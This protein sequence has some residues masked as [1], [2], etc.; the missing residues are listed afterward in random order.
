[1]P[2]KIDMSREEAAEREIGST[3]VS[4]GVKV[5]LVALFLTSLLAIP[6]IQATRGFGVKTPTN[7]PGKETEIFARLAEINHALKTTTLNIEKSLEE[8]SFLT[9]TL[10][11]PVQTLAFRWFGVGNE[12]VYVAPDGWLFY[13]PD[14]DYALESGHAPASQIDSASKALIALHTDLAS[15]GIRLILL[16]VPVKPV[17]ESSPLTE[18]TDTTPP[19]H[20]AY[21]PFLASLREAGVEVFDP[22]NLLIEARK[23]TALPQY[24]KTDT[25]WTPAAMETVAA[26]LAKSLEFPSQNTPALR[27]E[28]PVTIKNSGDL[29]AMLQLLPDTNADLAESAE[30]HPIKLPDGSPWRPDAASDVLLLGDSFTNIYS[31]PDLGWG[32]GAG[33]AE[34][35]SWRL[36]R[37]IDRIAINAGGSLTVR[38]NLARNPTRLDGK[39][40]VIYEFAVR[41]LTS[42]DWRPL[43]IPA[44]KSSASTAKSSA[45]LTGILKAISPLPAPGSVPYK[46]AVISLHLVEIH[47]D[48]G[49][50]ALVFARGMIG[51]VP[52]TA[53]RLQPGDR[54][55]LDAVRWESVENEFGAITRIE[56]EGPAADLETIYWAKENPVVTPP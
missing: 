50:E 44:A 40:I 14:V 5:L 23:S 39:K 30:I 18:K 54:I 26:A 47:G 24:L 37:P 17:V 41:E 12:K 52:T 49:A 15:R 8:H 43:S 48:P 42:G 19:H 7:E 10:L 27:R 31:T 11:P 21:G 13:R 16:P 51:N 4:C 35:L 55:S 45:A 38:Q 56:F 53:S 3:S 6:L 29:A 32:E 9:K 46:D 25:H 28:P 1:M 20:T 36:G 33:L 22:T 2:P 34:H